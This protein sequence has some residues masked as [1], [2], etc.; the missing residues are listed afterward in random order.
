MRPE[1]FIHYLM[2]FIELIYQELQKLL[3]LLPGT[4]GTTVL[5]LN[6]IQI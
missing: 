4:I 5:K 3:C 2:G 1:S 6:I